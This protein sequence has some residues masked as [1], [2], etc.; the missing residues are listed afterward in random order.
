MSPSL[1]S[2]RIEDAPDLDARFA[3]GEDIRPLLRSIA[4]GLAGGALAIAIDGLIP[5]AGLAT[6]D[7][8]GQVAIPLPRGMIWPALWADA[9]LGDPHQ[10]AAGIAGGLV[11]A[12]LIAFGYA[13]GQLRRFLPGPAWLRGLGLAAALGLIAMPVLLPRAAVWLAA[14]MAGGGGTAAAWLAG[15]ALI[16]AKVG[17]GLAVYGVVVGVLNPPA[18]R[19]A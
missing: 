18:I 8:I 2:T 6:F 13:Y 15:A 16:C 14:G 4:G 19:R 17:L 5:L 11:L 3:P 1:P 10:T 12:T 9:L 7:P